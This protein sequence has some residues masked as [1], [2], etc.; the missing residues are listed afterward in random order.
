MRA[1]L[2]VAGLIMATIGFGWLFASDASGDAVILPLAMGFIGIWLVIIALRGSGGRSGGYDSYDGRRSSWSSSRRSSGSRSRRSSGGSFS[3]F[4]GGG[5]G[6]FRSFGRSSSRS[7]SRSRSS[8]SRKS[9]G[10]R[11]SR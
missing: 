5:S 6:G 4:G 1:F 9:G 3:A 7:K 11:K 8:G 2:V 10:G